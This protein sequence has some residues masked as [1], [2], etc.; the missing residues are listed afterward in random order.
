MANFNGTP[1][2]DTFTGG[3]AADV[4]NG[5]DG[6]DRLYGGGGNDTMG[7]G[8]GNDL[9]DGGNGNDNVDGGAGND[10][11]Y[12]GAGDD[13][14]TYRL[15]EN[16]GAVDVYNGGNGIDVLR[17]ELTQAEWSSSAVQAQLARYL[18][19]LATVVRTPR[20]EVPDGAASDFTFDFGGGT[21]LTVGMVENL[22]IAVGGVQIDFNAPSIR[23]FTNGRVTEDAT[24]PTLSATGSIGFADLNYGDTHLVSAT[25]STGNPLGGLLTVA[26][27]DAATGDGFGQVRWSYSVANASTQFL[28]A[29]QTLTETFAVKIVDSGGRSVTQQIAVVIT[30]A[31]DVPVITSAAQIGAVAEDSAQQTVTGTIRFNDV[32]LSD[33]HSASVAPAASNTTALGSLML[34]SVSEAVNAAAGSVGWTYTLDNAAAQY[35]GDGETVIE[36]YVVTVRDPSGATATQTIEVTITGAADGPVEHAPR[37][38]AATLTGAVVEDGVSVARGTFAGTDQDAGATLTWSVTPQATTY[39]NVALGADGVSWIYTLKQDSAAVQLLREGESR[40]DS[41]VLTLT[42]NTGRTDTRTVTVTITGANDVAS[43]G[44]QVV[45]LTEANTS[46][47][48]DA[49]GLL[50]VSDVDAN[51][52]QARTG[53]ADWTYGRF[54]VQS[55]GSWSFVGNG[56]HDELAAG[57]VVEQVFQ[58]MSLDGSASGTVTIRIAGTNDAPVIAGDST[59]ALAEDA[60]L[61]ASGAMTRADPDAGDDPIWSIVPGGGQ[62]HG[63]ASIDAAGRWTYVLDND[64][65]AIQQLGQGDELADSFDVLVTDES[66]AVD[67]RTVQVTIRGTGDAPVIAA[68]GDSGA[69]RSDSVVPVGGVLTATDADAGDTQAW[70]AGPASY[71]TVVMDAGAWT[72]RVDSSAAAV[73][74]L[75]PGATLEDRFTATVTDA[76]GLV[77]AR[78]VVITITGASR[79]SAPVIDPGN[80]TGTVKEDA[81]LAAGAT[82]SATDADAGDTLTWSIDPSGTPSFGSATI[83]PATGQWGYTLDNAAAQALG[84]NDTVVDRFSVIVTDQT[85]L[86][87][88]RQVAITVRGTGDA[89]VIVGLPTVPPEVREDDPPSAPGGTGPTVSGDLDVT[90]ADAALYGETHAWSVSFSQYGTMAIDASTGQWTFTLNNADPQVQRLAEGG[91]LLAQNSVRVID[92]DGLTRFQ[93]VTIRIVGRD[94]PVRIVDNGQLAGAVKEDTQLSTTLSLAY[95]EDIGEFAAWTVGGAPRYGTA[96]F[97][98]NSGLLTYRLD[99]TLAAVQ[100]LAEGQT[101][102]DTFLVTATSTNLVN[103]SA[104]TRQITITINGTND[105]PVALDSLIATNADLPISGQLAARDAEPGNLTFATEGG[106]FHGTLTLSADGRYTYTPAAGYAGTDGFNFTVT[107]AQGLV[108]RGHAA[109]DVAPGANGAPEADVRFIDVAALTA[110]RLFDDDP[111]I[112]PLTG[113]GIRNEQYGSPLSAGPVLLA[114]PDGGHVVIY[115]GSV[116]TA[117]LQFSDLFMQR[118]D[119]AGAAL[120]AREIVNV[121]RGGHQTDPSAAVLRSASGQYLGYVVTWTSP[122]GSTSDVFMQRFDTAGNRL[123]SEQRV[124]VTTTLDQGVSSV[125]SVGGGRYVVTWTSNTGTTNGNDV[126]ARIYASDGTAVSTTD[127]LVNTLRT[128]TQQASKVVGLDDGTGRFAIVWQDGVLNAATGPDGS[129]TGLYARIFNANGTASTPAFQVNTTTAGDQHTA[130]IAAVGS[131]FVVTWTADGSNPLDNDVYAQRFD[132]AGQRLGNEFRVNT[133]HIGD[134]SHAH[135]EATPG[136]GFIVSWQSQGVAGAGT[137]DISAQRFDASGNR[138]GEEFIVNTLGGTSVGRT[139]EVDPTI[140]VSGGGALIAAWAETDPSAFYSPAFQNTGV[141][142]RR[143]VGN[144]DTETTP[145]SSVADDGG[146]ANRGLGL[147]SNGAVASL[148]DGGH[149][150]VWYAPD[151]SFYRT[152]HVFMQRY[153]AQ[154]LK[155]GE[156]VFVRAGDTAGLGEYGGPTVSGLSNGGWVVAFSDRTHVFTQTFD[157]AGNAS[158]PAQQDAVTSNVWG[159]NVMGMPDGG[160]A[161]VWRDGSFMA[162]IYDAASQPRGGVLMLADPPSGA[163]TYYQDA[164]LLPN[165]AGLVIA[166]TQSGSATFVQS[167]DLSGTPIGAP[168]SLPGTNVSL[169]TWGAGFVAAWEG[170]DGK[171]H[172]QLYASNGETIGQPIAAGTA[173]GSPSV[174]S[175]PDGSGVMFWS[176]PTPGS[177]SALLGQKFDANGAPL[178]GE[179][180]VRG[181]EPHLYTGASLSND[182]DGTLAITWLGDDILNGGYGLVRHQLQI[183]DLDAATIPLSQIEGDAAVASFANATAVASLP[184]GGHLL[185]YETGGSSQGSAYVQ[186]FDNDGQTA[187]TALQVSVPGDWAVLPKIGVNTDGSSTVVWES[188]FQDGSGSG[189]YLQRL[190]AAGNPIGSQQRVNTTVAGNQVSPGIAVLADGGVV[191]SWTGDTG[192]ATRATDIYYRVF[193]PSGTA[194]T[195]ELV[196]NT[197]TTGPQ[198]ASGLASSVTALADGRFLIHW[199]ENDGA[200]SGVFFRIFNANGSAASPVQL[201]ANQTTVGEQSS[202][203]AIALGDGFLIT[204]QSM[205]QPGDVADIYAQRFD[206]NGAALGSETRVNAWTPAHQGDPYAVALADGGFVVFWDSVGAQGNVASDIAGRRFDAGG[207]PIGDEFLVNRP[208]TGTYEGQPVA[209]LRADGTLVVAWSASAY[210]NLDQGTV[211]QTVIDSFGAAVIAKTVTGGAGNDALVGGPAADSLNG[212]AGDDRLE[213]QAGADRLTGGAGVDTFVFGAGAGVGGADDIADFAPGVDSIRLVNE[214]GT[215]FAGMGS[216][217]LSAEQLLVGGLDAETASTRVIYDPATGSLYFDP[218][219]AGG[220][221]PVQLAT[222]QNLPALI[223]P[224]DVVV[225]PPGP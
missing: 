21:R 173:G 145:L 37:I 108:D 30:G 196:A 174:I 117:G 212:A 20:G 184:S 78:E 198:F 180:V 35:L 177:L 75:A 157:V 97:Q 41:F 183:N 65:V 218:D 5:N 71:G 110:Q 14:L 50:T 115:E 95:Q 163:G 168:I 109:I 207:S 139:D 86:A 58:V 143:I 192:N 118:F 2:D 62:V 92:S 64:S 132:S 42:D 76:D 141:V 103:P 111:V 194:V 33:N 225:G 69:V 211:E 144:P 24:T 51:Q 89:P 216:G 8:R 13:R 190:D 120:S 22:Q 201:R 146:V 45:A 178:G 214:P 209:T 152:N 200:G 133:W 91:S 114:L 119:S 40:D 202:P 147:S 48:L 15:A 3:S 31:N 175:L 193:N 155:V 113:D 112:S 187:G 159:A 85:G 6:A 53:T 137:S 49:S 88:T 25:P 34:A 191:V 100:A 205:P 165:G 106:P 104:D 66:G 135:V 140:A 127:I 222:L 32:D 54:S 23:D 224:D 63:T 170:S 172:A 167:F 55:D 186:R 16:A 105:K 206:A 169:T 10:L 72:Y 158:P 101:L 73:V 179:F 188:L 18:R 79:G 195:G 176:A 26:L 87:A 154:G 150:I 134:Q 46:A 83:D 181:V 84:E 149:V 80:D 208:D 219:G 166:A 142:E 138:V 93:T 160:Y 126:F 56:A 4:I 122:F 153:D 197:N 36:R 47:A 223:R 77:T 60:V 129:G 215:V 98:N 19:H 61:S 128:G 27:A 156:P 28:A 148:A 217:A 12:G 38:T 1:G 124:N 136:G 90:D 123:G 171:N 29:G 162:R 221:A 164:A 131:G 121:T 74:A 182:V 96:S 213:G 107:D 204:W 9:L 7:G 70:T 220:V 199:V 99:N 185:A 67:R 203:S 81:T 102:T 17:L 39:G 210:S 82:L 52:A 57:Q 116:T 43:V 125:A 130:S 94:D 44:S 11:V 189:I 161:V 151:P 68:G 59:A